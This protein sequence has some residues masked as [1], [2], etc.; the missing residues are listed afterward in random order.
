MYTKQQ[1][2]PLA[3][4][5]TTVPVDPLRFVVLTGEGFYPGVALDPY[6]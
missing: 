6:R 3:S 5:Q 1:E 2:C 4:A